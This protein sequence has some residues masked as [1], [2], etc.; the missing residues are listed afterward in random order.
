MWT[1]LENKKAFD[2]IRVG[3]TGWL[4]TGINIHFQSHWVTQKSW[5]SNNEADGSLRSSS[6]FLYSNLELLHNYDTE[7]QDTINRTE[8]GKE[9]NFFPYKSGSVLL[10]I[11]VTKYVSLW[12]QSQQAAC[13][14]QLTDK[15]MFPKGG[16][17]CFG[18]FLPDNNLVA[19]KQNTHRTSCQSTHM[20]QGRKCEYFWRSRR[21]LEKLHVLTSLSKVMV[22]ITT[23][24]AAIVKPTTYNV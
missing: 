17:F 3:V 24:S 10:P 4:L 22:F 12:N 13:Q 23:K 19:S 7:R 15:S 20:K 14:A 2:T 5:L 11:K 9:N 16:L 8:K 18:G 6:S 21:C 1:T